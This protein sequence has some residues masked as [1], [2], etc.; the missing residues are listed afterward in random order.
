MQTID[1]DSPVTNEP[2]SAAEALPLQQEPNEGPEPGA[3][4]P[5]PDGSEVVAGYE[6][7]S[8]ET[9]AAPGG[10]IVFPESL[11]GLRDV[12]EASFGALPP[13]PPEGVMEA[14]L[15]VDDRI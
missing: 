8:V 6:R 4:T 13:P 5:N 7:I 3:Q 12:G 11:E 9:M 15:G 10:E 14:I 1:P 2:L